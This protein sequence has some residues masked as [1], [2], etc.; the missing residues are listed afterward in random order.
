MEPCHDRKNTG[1][2][3]IPPKLS[4][5]FLAFLQAQLRGRL[6][7]RPLFI[8]IPP[9]ELR[10]LRGPGYHGTI[11]SSLP[12]RSTCRFIRERPDMSGHIEAHLRGDT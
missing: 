2:L 9:P 6:S 3:V 1:L 12:V 4:G 7:W 5:I 8:S 11:S 10:A